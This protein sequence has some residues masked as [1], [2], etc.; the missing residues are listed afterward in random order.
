MQKTDPSPAQGLASQNHFDIEQGLLG[1]HILNC[2]RSPK[3]RLTDLP[4]PL[5]PRL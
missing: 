2:V 5:V 1:W 3:A 4:P